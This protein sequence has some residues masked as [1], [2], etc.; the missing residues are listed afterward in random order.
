M[1][2]LKPFS[3]CP[4]Q[5]RQGDPLKPVYWYLDDAVAAKPDP[6]NAEQYQLI[7]VVACDAAC[8]PVY[9]QQVLSATAV[10]TGKVFV[11]CGE[12]IA[13]GSIIDRLSALHL[14]V[15]NAPHW[16]PNTAWIAAADQRPCA[17]LSLIQ[18]LQ[19]LPE[20]AHVEP[21][22]LMQVQYR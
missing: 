7:D 5:L 13:I 4:Q 9:R 8:R 14:V 1:H 12:G 6:E 17:P 3:T 15:V 18:Q 11:R 20:V 10:A 2:Q 21:Q 19:L 16:A 22:L